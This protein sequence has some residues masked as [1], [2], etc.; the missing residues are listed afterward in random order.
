M[1]MFR[2]YAGD[3]EGKKCV[4]VEQE[5]DGLT[6]RCI[7]LDRAICERRANEIMALADILWPQEKSCR[8]CVKLE[9]CFQCN[10]DA[11]KVCGRWEK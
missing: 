8:T 11:G 4:V 9:E 10:P 2:I 1:S 6:Q 5:I 7:L 3:N